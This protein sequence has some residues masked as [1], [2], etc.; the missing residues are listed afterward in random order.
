MR[1]FLARLIALFQRRRLDRELSD[2][3]SAHIEMAIADN[4]ARGMSPEGARRAAMT[5]FGS[6]LHTQEA[7]R[8]R[9]RFPLLESLL[10]D[11]RYAGCAR[12]TS[13]SAFLA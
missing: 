6:V 3:I 9:Q 7:Y 10:Q 11:V 12:R 5:A 4:R 8:D 1:P 2:E 13:C